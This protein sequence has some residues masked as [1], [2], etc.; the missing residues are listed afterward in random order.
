MYTVAVRRDFIANHTLIGGDWGPE[1][2]PHAHHYLV[3]ARLY[4]EKLDRHGYLLDICE[5]ETGLDQLVDHFRDTSL[6]DLPEFKELNPSLEHFARIFCGAL[7][8]TINSSVLS[9]LCIKI[10]EN[11]EAWA[12]YR[13][14]F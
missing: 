4:G 5:V 8:Q 9:A 14:D 7:L 1:N 3:E 13:K 2:E 11:D 6:N 12:E 10:W